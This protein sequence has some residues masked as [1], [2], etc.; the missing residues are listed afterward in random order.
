MMRISSRLPNC[1]HIQFRHLPFK[2]NNVTQ[3]LASQYPP[4]QKKSRLG[5][6][7]FGTILLASGGAVVY[8]KYDDDFRKQVAD[9]VPYADDGI[10]IIFQEEKTITDTLSSALG[11]GP[12]AA[13]DQRAPDLTSQ[14]V[15]NTPSPPQPPPPPKKK[16]DKPAEKPSSGPILRTVVPLEELQVIEKIMAD[17]AVQLS[18][19]YKVIGKLLKEELIILSD[20][21][22]KSS[23]RLNPDLSSII[24]ERTNKLSQALAQE[25]ARVKTTLDKVNELRLK[26]GSSR[27]EGPRDLVEL[28]KRRI[29]QS[30]A[31]M[32]ETAAL[33]EDR[34]LKVLAERT[35]EKLETSRKAFVE[36]LHILFPSLDVPK[37]TLNLESSQVDLFLLYSY[38]QVKLLQDRIC[39]SERKRSA[40]IKRALSSFASSVEDQERIGN[41]VS[42]QVVKIKH[43]MEQELQ[44][45]VKEIKAECEAQITQH[46]AR[47][48]EAHLLTVQDLEEQQET[49]LQQKHSAIMQDLVQTTQSRNYKV[50]SEM[51]KQMSEIDGLVKARADADQSAYRAQMLWSAC[52]SLVRSLRRLQPLK[53][54]DEKVVSIKEEI[55]ALNSTSLENDQLVAAVV[56]GIPEEA[57]KRGVFTE[58]ALIERFKK[59]EKVTKGVA[60]VPEEGGSLSLYMLSWI[61]S[62]LLSSVRDYT[63]SSVK[64]SQT[65]PQNISTLEAIQEAR[66]W[67]DRGDLLQAL[68][69]MNLLKG[70]SRRV[71]ADWI[72][73]TKIHLETLQAA[74]ALMAHAVSVGML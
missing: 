23:D 12:E 54:Y 72:R 8:A 41:E 25:E 20:I 63:H 1:I 74:E 47:A 30:A 58:E 9:Y 61:Q 27:L 46:L 65:V 7:T 71:A 21:I 32:K 44:S 67:I 57:L 24:Q 42:D 69:Y 59:V 17:S 19:S 26:V 11:L 38:M 2:P 68:R 50:L 55:E 15:K 6:Y 66:Y 52:H 37:K 34:N 35:W 70:Y 16:E 43:E 10:K 60:L 28:S 73:E 39:E 64:L 5:L 14:N 40:R 36:E 62:F 56:K 45:K 29:D 49:K 33:V 51:Q 53:H 4:K 48:T 31:A 13:T 3:R 22:D 18:K